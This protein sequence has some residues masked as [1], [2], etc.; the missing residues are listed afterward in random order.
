[1]KVHP[2]GT[3]NMAADEMISEVNRLI[4]S[5]E[6]P[7]DVSNALL[8]AALRMVIRNQKE[9]NAARAELSRSLHERVDTVVETVGKLEVR[10]ADL[11]ETGVAHPSMRYMFAKARKEGM[12]WAALVV[13]VGLSFWLPLLISES[14]QPILEFVGR[15]LGF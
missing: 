9:A 14:R 11:E 4:E 8:F 6:L 7:Q 13:G 15:L 12:F 2:K 1:M 10:V 3:T 5:D